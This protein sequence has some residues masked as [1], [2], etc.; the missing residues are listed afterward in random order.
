[1]MAPQVHKA[2]SPLHRH[3]QLQRLDEEYKRKD[4]EED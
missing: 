4:L 2:L 1:M 3:D